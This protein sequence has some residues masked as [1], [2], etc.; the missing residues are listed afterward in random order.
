MGREVRYTMLKDPNNLV[1]L[2]ELRELN[3]KFGEAL[4]RLCCLPQNGGNPFL[5]SFVVPRKHELRK[6]PTC[7]TDG[8][9]FYW[10]VEYITKLSA[11]ELCIEMMHEALHIALA[12][13]HKGSTN[14]STPNHFIRNLAI[15]VVV[16]SSIQKTFNDA[17]YTKNPWTHLTPHDLDDVINGNAENFCLPDMKFFDKSFV[18]IYKYIEKKA[19]HLNYKIVILGSIDDLE[20][21]DDD[22]GG[23][24][25]HLKIDLSRE[26]VAT[27]VKKAMNFAIAS[28]MK[29]AGSLPGEL[30][31]MLD[32]I[33]NPK[34]SLRDELRNLSFRKNLEA[35]MHRDHSRYRRR[36]LSHGLYFPKSHSIKNRVLILLD[37]SGSMST[38]DMTRC[39]SETQSIFGEAVLIPADG[40]IY[41]KKAQS[42]RDTTN[43]Q[44]LSKIEC[45]GRGG[46]EFKDFF[47]EFPQHVGMDFDA[48]VAMTDGYVDMKVDPP[49]LPVLWILPEQNEGFKPPFGKVFVIPSLP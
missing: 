10:G 38:N 48:I 45:H 32:D 40:E 24:D 27:E 49:P 16:D 36:W 7:A 12:H 3:K 39:V 18:E 41:W 37:T 19:P 2:E 23:R 17:K 15:D 44:E 11:A 31:E 42:I 9:K 28:G 1:T 47:R 13:C 21:I 4:L 22:G 46:T 20:K 30:S 43:V 35:G 29:Q 25:I 5:Y 26:D 33:E 34:L 8:K 14:T 6:I